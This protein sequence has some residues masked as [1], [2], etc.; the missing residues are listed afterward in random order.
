MKYVDL[1]LSVITSEIS[2]CEKVLRESE[3]GLANLSENEP[4]RV[5]YRRRI[6]EAL[7]KQ[8]KLEQEQRHWQTIKQCTQ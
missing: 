6:I 3:S 7:R 2:Q 1:V 5:Y 4:G 8:A